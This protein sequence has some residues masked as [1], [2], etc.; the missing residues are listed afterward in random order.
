MEPNTVITGQSQADAAT[1]SISI[2][3]GQVAIG[4]LI[5]SAAMKRLKATWIRS[6]IRKVRTAILALAAAVALYCR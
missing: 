2:V 6:I 1:C 4:I 3:E 5:S